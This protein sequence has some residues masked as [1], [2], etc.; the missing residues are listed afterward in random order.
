MLLIITYAVRRA[1]T[2]VAVADL[3]LLIDIHLLSPNNFG[4]SMTILR[5]FFQKLKNPV[6]FHYYCSYCYEYIGTS[7]CQHCSNKHCL[8]DFR[9]KGALEYFIVLPLVTQLQALLASKSGFI[10]SL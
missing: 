9:K 4:N 2:G 1:L 5:R 10:L 7:K 3:L 8:K 6:E